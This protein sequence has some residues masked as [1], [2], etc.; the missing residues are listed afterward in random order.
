MISVLAVDTN[1]GAC[2]AS[3]RNRCSIYDR[4][5]LACRTVPFHYS[6]AEAL[7]GSDLD[8][9]VETPG[10]ACDTG[11]AAEIVLRAG[12]IVH[13]GIRQVRAEA[14]DLAYNDRPWTAAILRGMK[15][16]AP[17]HVALPTL[18]EIEANA[19]FGATAVSMRLAWQIAADAG[20]MGADECSTIMATQLATIERELA[21]RTCRE[22]A[23]S[24]LLEMASDY[25]EA[26]QAVTSLTL[27]GPLRAATPAR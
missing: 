20:L 21:L 11:E 26:L 9:F 22:K 4:R 16:D 18:A 24:L 8:A 12:R 25:R 27:G 17:P 3:E 5:P 19:A 13:S 7:A 10:Y 2:G 6:R 23:R 15:A 14:L 1:P